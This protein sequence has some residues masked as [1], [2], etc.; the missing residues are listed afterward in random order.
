MFQIHKRRKSCCPQGHILQ[1]RKTLV[2]RDPFL[3]AFPNNFKI[4]VP[5]S[6]TCSRCS[7]MIYA[8]N[9]A[10]VAT[11]EFCNFHLCRSC[12]ADASPISTMDCEENY[13][14]RRRKGRNGNHSDC[15]EMC[16]ENDDPV[17]VIVTNRYNGMRPNYFLLPRVPYQRYPEPSNYGWK[18]TGSC[19]MTKTEFYE[20]NGEEGVVMLDFC[21][22]TG[23]VQTVLNH[24]LDGQ[25]VL[26]A[27][28]KS[29]LPDVFIKILQNPQLS[30]SRYK[31]RL[32]G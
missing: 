18:F 19:E 2:Q 31:R 3:Q 4:H 20:R 5:S 12:I 16:C 22:T 7:C 14:S 10:T 21:F 24:R 1:E 30:D 25:I 27:K 13:T 8:D 29:L 32:T 23:T 15:V 11:C 17:K 26:F 6:L 9:Q 28:G